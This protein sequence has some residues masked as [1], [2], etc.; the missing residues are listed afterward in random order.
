M[1]FLFEERFWPGISY[2]WAPNVASA[3]LTNS[4]R[5]LLSICADPAADHVNSRSGLTN[6]NANADYLFLHFAV[7]TVALRGWRSTNTRSILTADW[8]R[9]KELV[10]TL[11][12]LLL[13]DK[14]KM[15]NADTDFQSDQLSCS[16]SHAVAGSQFLTG[17]V[18]PP[19]PPQVAF[20]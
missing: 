16:S 12:G 10:S 9:R 7:I 19:S 4:S 20:G 2:F 6:K 1:C 17:S 14:T 18:N 8:V 13:E 5:S 3:V 15:L 11:I